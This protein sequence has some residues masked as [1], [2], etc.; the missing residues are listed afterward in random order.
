MSY[1]ML[2]IGAAAMAICGVLFENT[3]MV[4]GGLVLMWIGVAC[5]S[6]GS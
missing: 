2:F 3:S 5:L 6:G 4:T 1:E